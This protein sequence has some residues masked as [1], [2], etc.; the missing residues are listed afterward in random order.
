MTIGPCGSHGIEL[1]D[2]ED[3]VIRNVVIKDT[4]GVGIYIFGSR[5]VDVVE[6]R[7]ENSVA[8][9]FAG[10]SRGI[11][12]SCNTIENV[13]GPIPAGQFVQFNAV[14][15]PDNTISCN[16]G[17]NIPGDGRQPEDGISL[18]KSF[19]VTGSPILVAHNLLIGGGPSKSGGG[20][21][22]GDDG[23]AYQLARRN[24]LVDPG[25]HGMGIAS[26]HNMAILENEIYGRKQPFTNVGIYVWN[27]YLHACRSHQVRGNHVNWSSSSGRSNG[28]WDGRN[29]GVV[30]GLADNDFNARIGPE[31]GLKPALECS[32]ASAGRK[33]HQ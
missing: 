24:I 2:S 23:G 26:G 5:S 9:V 29:C 27:Q 17:R 22:L 18:Y 12:V 4:V 8:G 6:N 31:I 21:M 3:V 20:I 33:R 15:G 30:E 19:G 14:E 13:R 32:C 16:L 28:W 11:N 1:R 7:I 10:R 25:Q